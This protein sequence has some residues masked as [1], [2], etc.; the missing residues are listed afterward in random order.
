MSLKGALP[1][2]GGGAID[3]LVGRTSLN[4]LDLMD[5]SFRTD[6]KK[7]FGL[8]PKACVTMAANQREAIFARPFFFLSSI[9]SYCI[10]SLS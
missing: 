7:N 1:A 10:G 2:A 4:W 6:L 5:W 9:S 8:T 3:S